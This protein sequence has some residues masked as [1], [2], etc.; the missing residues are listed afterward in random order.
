MDYNPRGISFRSLLYGWLALLFAAVADAVQ[1]LPL[2][3]RG[4]RNRRSIKA[5]ALL[6]LSDALDVMGCVTAQSGQA[7]QAFREAQVYASRQ[8]F[9]ARRDDLTDLRPLPMLPAPQ[10]EPKRSVYYSTDGGASWRPVPPTDPRALRPLKAGRPIALLTPS[11]LV[12]PDGVEPE[13][14]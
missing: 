9:T 13:L 4:L 5:Q 6:E 12:P 10:P 11:P 3:L 7:V 14:N 2:R 8:L 1:S